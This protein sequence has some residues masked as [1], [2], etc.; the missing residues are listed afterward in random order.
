MAS[1]APLRFINPYQELC[2]AYECSS[3]PGGETI[4]SRAMAECTDI[5]YA[6]Q[7]MCC[8][9][10]RINKMLKNK[11]IGQ[12]TSTS[13]MILWGNTRKCLWSIQFYSFLFFLRQIF[14][15]ATNEFCYTIYI[16]IKCIGCKIL[17][18]QNDALSLPHLHKYDRGHKWALGNDRWDRMPGGGFSVKCLTIRTCYE[19]PWHG[20]E[21]YTGI[22]SCNYMYLKIAPYVIKMFPALARVIT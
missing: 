15:T 1:S 18:K 12:I 3:R 5:L 21:R 17:R 8:E 2:L 7:A 9:Y 6:Q 22:I 19:C 13:S 11:C 4:V 10:I 20:G 16:L 14:Y